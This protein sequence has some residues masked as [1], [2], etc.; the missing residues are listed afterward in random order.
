MVISS[1][2]RGWDWEVEVVL[3]VEL[4]GRVEVWVRSEAL[5][6]MRNDGRASELWGCDMPRLWEVS[7]RQRLSEAC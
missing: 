6:L 7:R 1:E 2:R 5:F 4:G 3:E